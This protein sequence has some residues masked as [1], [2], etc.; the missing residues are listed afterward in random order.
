L[1]KAQKTPEKPGWRDYYQMVTTLLMAGLG[2]YILWQTI[3]VRWAM[4]SLI[5]SVVLLLFA[6]YRTRMMW[7][8]FSQRGKHGV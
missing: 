5:F 3:F 4:P 1:F 6:F 8:Y 2:I 7:V